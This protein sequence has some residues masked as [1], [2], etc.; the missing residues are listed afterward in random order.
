[1]AGK[2]FPDRVEVASASHAILSFMQ[3]TKAN[4]IFLVLLHICPCA[5]PT[6]E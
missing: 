4:S 1:M 6:I 3:L 5:A 2:G